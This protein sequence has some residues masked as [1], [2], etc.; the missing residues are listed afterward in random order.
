MM[1]TPSTRKEV[2]FE[3]APIVFLLFLLLSGC[4]FTDLS[5]RRLDSI[6]RPNPFFSL[7][8][9]P[10]NDTQNSSLG[11][12]LAG[13]G[14]KAASFSM[15]V[16]Q[17]LVKTEMLYETDVISTV[18][19][20]GYAAYFLYSR[21]LR[22]SGH[23]RLD[24]KGIDTYFS[25]CLPY[26]YK[27]KGYLTNKLI[28]NSSEVFCEDRSCDPY[29]KLDHQKDWI[30]PSLTKKFV[31]QQHLRFSQ[32][33]LESTYTSGPAKVDM[34]T[35]PV[36]ISMLASTALS[37]PASTLSNTLFDWP[38]NLS[39]TRYAYLEGIGLSYG[40]YPK[41]SSIFRSGTTM[42]SACDAGLYENCQPSKGH[43]I[44]RPFIE[45]RYEF[46]D[47]KKLYSRAER[48]GLSIPIWML[49]ATVAPSRSLY[50]WSA[51]NDTDLSK[52]SFHMTADQ[53][54]AESCGPIDLEAQG[55]DLLDAVTASAAFFDA[56]QKVLG[57]PCR[58]LAAGAQHLL[59][60]NWGLDLVNPNKDTT[61]QI[62]HQ[63][64]PFPLYWLDYLFD[65]RKPCYYRLIDGGSTDNLGSY[66]LIK[67][68]LKDVIISDHSGDVHGR[69]SDLCLLRNELSLRDNRHLHI[70]G[71]KDFEKNCSFVLRRSNVKPE[72]KNNSNVSLCS[73]E[74]DHIYPVS[75]W[76]YPFLVGCVSGSK[77]PESCK[78]NSSDVTRIWILK[79]AIDY[80]HFLK[81]QKPD[82]NNPAI[83]TCKEPMQLPCET[84]AFLAAYIGK[85]NRY[86]YPQFPQNSTV[87]MTIDSSPALYGAYRD[88]SSWNTTQ[89]LSFLNDVRKRSDGHR[90]FSELFEHQNNHKIPYGKS[91]E[92]VQ[93]IKSEGDEMDIALEGWKHPVRDVAREG[94][95]R[96]LARPVKGA[97]F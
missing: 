24:K 79:P 56:N 4:A 89:L 34:S 17:A 84:S 30:S 37:I 46:S 72:K 50:G 9:A 49:N 6:E 61:R 87:L 57:Q 15:G 70:P 92:D 81:V 3:K 33:L 23:K 63:M 88:L 1:P 45:G 54:F 25:D 36:Y 21:L 75:A 96:I 18:S 8:Q 11:V 44:N 64:L 71:L 16:L 35:K 26:D 78:T 28:A 97:T 7:S 38:V 47:L 62:V 52:Y 86:G 19:G 13:G 51:R 29:W 12:S 55:V 67:D 22:D 94:M 60:L 41:D 2:F 65:D 10:K 85:K 77:E 42:L 5:E 40:L 53:Q 27:K 68:K 74:A 66:K 80:P 69:F 48:K 73:S 82:E 59:N 43:E 14:T 91:V 32:D 95:R 58:F 76:P 39:P 93:L 20:G 83:A 90:Y 31:H